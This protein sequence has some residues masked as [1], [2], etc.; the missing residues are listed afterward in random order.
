M[1]ILTFI[2]ASLWC[3][4]IWRYMAQ[5]EDTNTGVYAPTVADLKLHDFRL[6]CCL[7]ARISKAKHRKTRP[8][9]MTSSSSPKRGQLNALSQP[10]EWQARAIS[11]NMLSAFTSPTHSSHSQSLQRRRVSVQNTTR[12][13]PRSPNTG[14][15]NT[16]TLNTRKPLRPLHPRSWRIH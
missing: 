5:C 6:G 4:W 10:R 16:R 8:C 12:R 13:V 15:H 7:R 3:S 14:A 1:Q 11:A 2:L 9:I